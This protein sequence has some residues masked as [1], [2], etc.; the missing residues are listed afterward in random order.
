MNEYPIPL[1]SL[2]DSSPVV[3]FGSHLFLFFIL[4]LIFIL[5][6]NSVTLAME[7]ETASE[8]PLSLPR[9]VA[10]GPP[11]GRQLANIVSLRP[12]LLFP[13]F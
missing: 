10:A 2:S 11:Q 4:Q 13:D 7:A 12:R 1:S 3:A 5:S 8:T 6:A 9:R